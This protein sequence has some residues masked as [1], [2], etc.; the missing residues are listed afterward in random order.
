MSKWITY[1]MKTQRCLT[2]SKID[3][4]DPCDGM[5]AKT[6]KASQVPC[7]RTMYHLVRNAI[8]VRVT[9]YYQH[10]TSVNKVTG[11]GNKNTSSQTYT[12][13]HIWLYT[14][15][16]THT[17]T[18]THARTHAHDTHTHTQT[19]THTHYRERQQTDRLRDWER[20]TQADREW[21]SQHIQWQRQ[22]DRLLDHRRQETRDT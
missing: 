21:Q 12:I 15:T 14:H 9:A 5:F 6:A 10:C 3:V 2:N 19:H 17:H 13:V 1:L 18:S 4:N 11:E 8:Q 7:W 20:G 16:W 22:A